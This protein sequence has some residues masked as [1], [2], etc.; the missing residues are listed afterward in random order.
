MQR[1]QRWGTSAAAI[2]LVVL[3]SCGGTGDGA[4]G[5]V[6]AMR[7][8]DSVLVTAPAAAPLARA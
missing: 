4:V 7:T 6:S 2:A 8:V 3:S 1:R 5:S